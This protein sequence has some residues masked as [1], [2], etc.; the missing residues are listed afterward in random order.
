MLILKKLIT[1]VREHGIRRALKG[2]IHILA[3]EMYVL[4]E[5]RFDRRFHVETSGIIRMEEYDIEAKKKE[6]AIRYQPTP[7][8]PLRSILK[9]LNIDHF[10]YTFIDVGSGKGRVLLLASEFP[11]NKIIGV[12]I[13]QQVHRIAE[14]NF[15]TWNNPKQKCWDLQSICIDACEYRFPEEPLVLFFFTPFTSPILARVIENLNNS[16]MEKPR[17]VYIIY[18]GSSQELTDLFRTLNFSLKQIHKRIP[19]LNYSGVLFSTPPQAT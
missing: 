3:V 8:K 17:S 14:K 13:S 16:I 10:Q 9:S 1:L 6:T 2:V 5:R 7:I 12:E 19:F 11:Y 4:F 18:F 15:E